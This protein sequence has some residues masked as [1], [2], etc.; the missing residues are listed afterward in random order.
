M[1]KKKVFIADDS[2]FTRLALKKMLSRYE[3][4]EVIGTARDGEE[5]V[6][7][8]L[9]LN[10]D[11]LLL[12]LEM[13]GL[14][15]FSVI[16]ILMKTNPIP[17]IVFSSRA[18]ADNIFKA[19][20]LGAVDFIPK[21]VS[22]ASEKLYEA[23]EE[24]IKKIRSVSMIDMKRKLLTHSHVEIKKAEGFL[25]LP[26]VKSL[27]PVEELPPPSKIIMIGASTGGPTEI[28]YLLSSLPP[29]LDIAILVAQHMPA[30]FTRAFAERLDKYSNYTVKEGEHRE[31]LRRGVVYISPGAHHMEVFEVEGRV[32]LRLTRKLP[33][34]KYTP[35]I[36]T[37]FKSGARVFG[38][39]AMAILLTGM[40]TDGVE[41][42]KYVREA[43]GFTI[44][45]SE[46]T[47]ILYGMP[48]GALEK[49]VA[50][51]VLPLYDIPSAIKR[52]A[53]VSAGGESS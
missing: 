35:S 34:D 50:E 13:P 51:R 14:D 11:L 40:G 39:R 28:T 46:E 9:K 26:K 36:D 32:R 47:S 25:L 1:N 4:V 49:G 17:I 21:P 29:K 45:E 53:T 22:R 24:L 5:A 20:E 10:P 7:K 12:D 30:G 23:E 44:A 8:I 52:W 18:S 2:A 16:R 19:M 43:G 42:M 3:D 15:G 33:E 31:L 41:G 38:K 37:L 48:R 6:T 27:Y